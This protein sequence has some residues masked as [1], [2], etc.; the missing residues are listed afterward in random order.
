MQVVL[1]YL[2]MYLI[3]D[4]Y[5]TVCLMIAFFIFL[6]FSAASVAHGS[7][8]ARGRI[9]AATASLCHKPQQREIQATYTTYTAAHGNA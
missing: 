7:F 9:G 4:A 8:Q 3:A 5:S 1:Q 6:L 2:W